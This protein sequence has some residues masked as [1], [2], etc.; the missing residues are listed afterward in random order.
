MGVKG[1][2]ER[3]RD[4]ED[5]IVAEGYVF[6]LERRG[7]LRA[8][9]FVPE[10][11]IEKP[12]AVTALHE[13]FVH[14]G[15]DVV[16]AFTYYCHRE[17]MRVIGREGDLEK[18]NR[19]A[20]RLARDV[21]NRTGTLMAGNICNT[22]VYNHKNPETAAE[23]RQI[24]KEQVEWA[25]EE[26]ADFIVG[27]TFGE[28][29]E[30]LLALEAIKIHGKG[31][32]AVITLGIASFDNRTFCGVPYLEALKKLEE[33]GADVVGLNCTRGPRTMLPLIAEAKA[34]CKVPIAALPVVYRTTEQCV[35]F[36][37]LNDPDTGDF[38]FPTELPALACSR[39]E[40]AEFG[41]K[42]KELGV[43]YVGLCCGNASHYL[44]EVAEAYGR[45][46]GACRYSPNMRQHF[47]WGEDAEFKKSYS[48]DLRKMLKAQP[49]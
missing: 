41:R 45:H 12:E 9:A 7:Y 37:A 33:A 46:P 40:I 28:L 18:I 1:L 2:L 24:F 20:L 48:D 5:V 11:V 19:Q 6:E 8:G 30:A 38:A 34:A 44:R 31:L 4:G 17:K 14:A 13:E 23:T 21:A 10:V 26:K 36:L 43:Q 47:I 32:P 49:K 39:K 35:N 29:G 3:L 16:L 42:C 22:T 15:S 25:V 27:E